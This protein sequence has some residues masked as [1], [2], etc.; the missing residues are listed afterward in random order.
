MHGKGKFKFTMAADQGASGRLEVTVAKVGD[1]DNTILVHSKANGQ[2]FPM[3][4]WN[5]F[6]SRL[7][8]ALKTLEK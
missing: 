8:E 6:H 1:E 3:K 7:D 4:D 5:G 2:D